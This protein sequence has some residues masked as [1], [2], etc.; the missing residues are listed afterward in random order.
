MYKN[1]ISKNKIFKIFSILLLILSLSILFIAPDIPYKFDGKEDIFSKYHTENDLTGERLW[2]YN[3]TNKSDINIKINKN[4]KKYNTTLSTYILHIKENTIRKQEI[5]K[6]NI[7]KSNHIIQNK[8]NSDKIAIGYS[9]NQNQELK[10][11]TYKD[12][13]YFLIFLISLISSASLFLYS[14]IHKN[15]NE[16]S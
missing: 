4:N 10:N 7:E 15:K 5:K 3:T 14:L 12:S 16:K 2:I 11:F 8:Y 1:K 9:S 13:I 6:I